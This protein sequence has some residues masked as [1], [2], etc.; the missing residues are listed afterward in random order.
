[1]LD[2]YDVLTAKLKP[3]FVFT[4]PFKKLY[5]KKSTTFLGNILLFSI[6]PI[7]YKLR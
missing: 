1:M 3:K 2:K 7:Y 4:N 6:K 5:K